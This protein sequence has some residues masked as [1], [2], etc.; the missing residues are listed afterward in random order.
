MTAITEDCGSQ[1]GQLY[2]LSVCFL[3]VIFF[4]YKCWKE[5]VAYCFFPYAYRS[6]C[7]GSNRLAERGS[8]TK[9][10]VRAFGRCDGVTARNCAIGGRELS[11]AHVMSVISLCAIKALALKSERSRVQ[12]VSC[13]EAGIRAAFY[14]R[15]TRP[16]STCTNCSRA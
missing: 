16:T 15:R 14:Q 4:G 1:P 3:L 10:I 7:L 11:L 8:D 5:Y 13:H 12:T 2:R 6:P 9:M